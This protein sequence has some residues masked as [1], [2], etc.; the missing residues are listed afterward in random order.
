MLAGIYTPEPPWN[1]WWAL[2]STGLMFVYHFSIL[3]ILGLV[4]EVNLNNMLCPAISDPFYGP[5][6]SWI[7]FGSRLRKYIDSS[8]QRKVLAGSGK[9]PGMVMIIQSSAACVMICNEVLKLVT[10]SFLFQSNV[11]A[12]S[13]ASQ[14]LVV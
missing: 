4:T 7:C 12:F 8:P 13:T 10:S 5:C 3:Q 2:L 14:S 1:F 9:D 11:D 6:F